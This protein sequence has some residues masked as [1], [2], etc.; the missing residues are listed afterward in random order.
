MPPDAEPPT[1]SVLLVDSSRSQ[2]RYWSEQLKRVSPNYQIVEAKDRESALTLSRSR[3][4][5]CVV[6]ELALGDQEG[7]QLLVDLNPNR[8]QVAV[9]VLTHMT[10]T[11]V[12][13]LA[14]LNGAHGCLVKDYTTGE[15]LDRAIQR[16]VAFVGQMPKED[17]HRPH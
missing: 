8:P 13:A 11:G 9:V 5:D 2:R 10:Q 16:A 17:R 15:E 6:L 12:W 1:T 3:S 4:F 14:R 7:F